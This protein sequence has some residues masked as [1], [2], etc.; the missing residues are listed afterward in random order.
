VRGALKKAKVGRFSD[1]PPEQ[2]MLEPVGTKGREIDPGDVFGDPK[3][4]S[5][6]GIGSGLFKYDR[7]VGAAVLELDTKRLSALLLRFDLT[8]LAKGTAVVLH[9]AQW[10]SAGEAEGGM[11]VVALAPS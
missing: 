4:A 3:L 2:V 9:G 10:N 8:N 1:E 5:Q 7:L 6:A 11:T